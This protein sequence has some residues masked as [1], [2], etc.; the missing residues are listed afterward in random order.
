MT[1]TNVFIGVDIGQKVDNTAICVAEELEGDRWEV[2]HLERMKLGTPYPKVA[3]RLAEVYHETVARVQAQQ[4]KDDRA[5]GGF[6]RDAGMDPPPDIR[7]RESVFV[8]IDSTGVGLPVCDFVRERAGIAEG[9]VTAVQFTAGEKLN[10]R[11][12]QREGTVAKTYLVSRLAALMAGRRIKLPRTSEAKALAD[13]LE[14]FEITVSD[15]ATAQFGAR[16][17]TH[18]DLCMGLGLA[19]LIGGSRDEVRV[20]RYA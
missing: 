17:G 9:H 6:M 15:A 19:V 20:E 18:D 10:V 4:T 16:Q 8:L 1:K 14:T 11:L 5:H 3:A 12:G 13:E 2:H 7:A